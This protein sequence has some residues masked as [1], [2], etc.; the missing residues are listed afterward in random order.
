MELL[1]TV[2]TKTCHTS[3][4]T[5]L[6]QVEKTKFVAFAGLPNDTLGFLLYDGPGLRSKTLAVNQTKQPT[7]FQCV[8]Q[9]LSSFQID[10]HKTV[11]DVLFY[12]QSH[13]N[14]LIYNV[15]TSAETKHLPD[16]HCNH[17]LCI[18]R[19]KAEAAHINSS[20][21]NLNYT[22][23]ESPA[24]KYGGL[25]FTEQL[26]TRKKQSNALCDSHDDSHGFGQTF[27]SQSFSQT[28]AL[29][30]YPE[31]SHISVALNVSQTKCPGIMVDDC[32]VHL[33]CM[34]VK[35][36]FASCALYLNEISSTTDIHLHVT[37]NHVLE[38]GVFFSLQE[39]TCF[40][41][42]L[43]RPS[44]YFSKEIYNNFCV[45]S[46]IPDPILDPGGTLE[47][48]VRGSFRIA[49]LPAFK[50]RIEIEGFKTRL[51]FQQM[52]TPGMICKEPASE[53]DLQEIWKEK[54]I[55]NFDQIDKKNNIS[56]PP[57]NKQIFTLILRFQYPPTHKQL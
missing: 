6:I 20:V 14:I 37:H 36:N 44:N 50:E 17:N 27:Y 25:V 57:K 45:F 4:D 38:L 29:Y 15:S 12:S 32:K 19:L 53:D 52:F 5:F 48:Q 3:L 54:L 40:V 55:M 22:G 16:K 21:P 10:D 9:V 46:L 24:C 30:W 2:V 26:N 7:T 47:Y 51:C 56:F 43:R 33:H 28:V 18:L 35:N 31:Y 8:L 39:N 41:I 1:S 42:Q 34:K 11:N 49:S 23:E 13:E